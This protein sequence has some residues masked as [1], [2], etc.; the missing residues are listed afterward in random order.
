MRDT[1]GVW[2]ASLAA[3]TVA[4]LAVSACGVITHTIRPAAAAQAH[5]SRADR[6]WIEQ[7]HQADMAEM[8]IGQLAE[9]DGGSKAI[10]S[11]GAVLSRDHQ[12]LDSAL[13]R[14]AERLNV[15]LPTSPSVPQTMTADQLSKESGQRFDQDFTAAMLSAHE[16]MIAATRYEIAHGSAAVVVSLAQQALPVLVKHLKMMQAA[17]ASSG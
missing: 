1:R 11:A 15:G 10:R 14:V 2:L 4:L 8:Q 7:A 3:C 16:A 6:S 12:A 9:L 17:A 5:V 13:I